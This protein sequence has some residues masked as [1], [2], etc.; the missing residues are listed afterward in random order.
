MGQLRQSTDP[1]HLQCAS[2]LQNLHYEACNLDDSNLRIFSEEREPL[3]LSSH[4]FLSTRNS[5][6][7]TSISC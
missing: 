2:D 5:R 1:L 4:T 6:V 3:E 7:A